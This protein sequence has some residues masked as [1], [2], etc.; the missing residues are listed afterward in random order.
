MIATLASAAPVN[1]TP[2]DL[3]IQFNA[4]S[5]SDLATIVGYMNSDRAADVPEGALRNFEAVQTMRRGDRNDYAKI[6]A[7]VDGD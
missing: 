2:E 7:L 5:P 4:R 1:L 6:L 3:A